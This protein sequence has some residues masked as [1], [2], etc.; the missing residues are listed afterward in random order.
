MCGYHVP[1][2]FQIT[3]EKKNHF[4]SNKYMNM[5]IFP[6]PLNNVISPVPIILYTDYSY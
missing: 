1:R 3:L 2:Y 6:N 4:T 5:S